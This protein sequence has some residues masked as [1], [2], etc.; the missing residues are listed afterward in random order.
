MCDT[1]GIHDTQEELSSTAGHGFDDLNYFSEDTDWSGLEQE[2]EL[3]D[4]S[5]EFRSMHPQDMLSRFIDICLNTCP[6]EEEVCW[7][8]VQ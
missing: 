1:D 6:S 8:A 3:N 2:L 4:W 5:M 7:T